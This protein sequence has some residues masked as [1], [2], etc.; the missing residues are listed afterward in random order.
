MIS[1]MTMEGIKRAPFGRPAERAAWAKKSA[2]A[3]GQR[4]IETPPP[5]FSKSIASM[6]RFWFEL[7]RRMRSPEEL[8]PKRN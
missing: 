5:W 4:P 8:R 6:T 7:T 2:L 1:L 3:L